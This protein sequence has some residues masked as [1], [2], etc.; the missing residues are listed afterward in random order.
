MAQR[1]RIFTWH[2]HGS[3]LF[4][5]SQGNYDIFIP[6]DGSGKEGYC[7]RGQTFPFG[8]N[9]IAVAAAAVRDMEFDVILYQ[10]H[11]N[12]LFDQYEILS[13]AQQ[14]QPRIFLQHDPP[15]HH[16]VDQCHLVDDPEVMLVHVTHFNR[17]MYD[18]NRTPSMVIEHGIT[19]PDLPYKGDIPRGLVVINNLPERGR[20]LGLDVFKYVRERVPLDLVGMGTGSLGLGEVL[21]PQ[22]PEFVSRYRFFFNPIRYTS[23]GLAV[24]EAMLLGVPVAG[25]ATTEMVTLIHD[26]ENGFLH[27]DVDYL[28]SRMQLLLADHGLARQLGAAGKATAMERFNIQRFCNE[29]EQLFHR[30]AARREYA[31]ALS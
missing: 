31:A 14:R 22:L 26:G 30:M 25:L 28:V 17:L 9:V 7:G 18:N 5:L 3:Y 10:T 21:H 19:V 1:L 11:Q 15:L 24:G 12:Y 4:Y 8:K 20:R 2:I 29:W 23:L 16:P 6:V 13:A 27:T